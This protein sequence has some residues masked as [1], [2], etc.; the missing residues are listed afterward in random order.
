MRRRAR[1][2][3]GAAIDVTFGSPDQRRVGSAPPQDAIAGARCACGVD[4][5]VPEDGRKTVGSARPSPS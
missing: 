3:S 2:N 4:T 1:T 5:Q